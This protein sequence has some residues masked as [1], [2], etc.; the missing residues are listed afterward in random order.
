M[1]HA[2]GDLIENA[3]NNKRKR[4]LA[5][6]LENHKK[7]IHNYRE[8]YE[9]EIADIDYFTKLEEALRFTKIRALKYNYSLEE[10]V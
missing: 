7:L 5:W 3:E 1:K 4:D 9:E 2:T 6:A 10:D 8:K